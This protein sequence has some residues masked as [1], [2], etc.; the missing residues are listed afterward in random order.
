MLTWNQT[1]G[2]G[3][4]AP[5]AETFTNVTATF[6]TLDTTSGSLAFLRWGYGGTLVFNSEIGDDHAGTQ[7]NSGLPDSTNVW[8]DVY[9]SYSP[10]PVDCTF[11][12]STAIVSIASLAVTVHDTV[13]PTVEATGG[14]L[15][16]PGTYAGQQALLFTAAD[17]NGSGVAKVTVSLGSTVVGTAQST[18]QPGSLQPCPASASGALVANTTLVPDGTY[19]VI[20]TAYDA[21]GDATPAQAGTVTIAN[22]TGTSTVAPPAPPASKPE[23]AVTTIRRNKLPVTHLL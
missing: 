19:P 17:D 7:L 14:S 20:V 11:P 22:Q 3:L 5:G 9:C 4:N 21:S 8:F 15:A 6:H 13:A 10:G 2:A 1:Y 23:R 12:S 16:T 18:C